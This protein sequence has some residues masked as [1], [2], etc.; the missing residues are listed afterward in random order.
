[1]ATYA[2]TEPELPMT[3]E[4]ATT[5]DD[6]SAL[7][8]RVLRMVD[9]LKSER[10]SRIEAERVASELHRSLEMQ[11]ADLRQANDELAGFKRERDEVRGRVE[12]LLQQLDDLTA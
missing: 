8:Q 9:L 6:F 10:E 3:H 11:R 4:A 7:E 5:A 1:M 2:L 12:R